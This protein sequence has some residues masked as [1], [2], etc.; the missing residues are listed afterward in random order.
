MSALLEQGST[1]TAREV[2]DDERIDIRPRP[3]GDDMLA[4]ESAIL[5]VHANALCCL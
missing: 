2:P 4:I 1:I 5:S 3:F